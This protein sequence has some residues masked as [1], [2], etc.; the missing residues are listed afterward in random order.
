MARLG[1]DAD[2]L[3]TLARNCRATVD[4]LDGARLSLD[5]TVRA[6]FWL[7]VE[8]DGFRTT[9]TGS[10]ARQ[11]DHIARALAGVADDLHRQAADQR[12]TSAGGGAVAVTGG[13]CD[14]GGATAPT[15]RPTVGPPPI[16]TPAEVAEWWAQLSPAQR[17][18][19]LAQHPHALGNRQGLPASGRDQ[20]NRTAMAQDLVRLE[21]AERNGSLSD[22][23][24]REL[25]NIRH[26]QEYL[27]QTHPGDYPL[28]TGQRVPV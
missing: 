1:A 6:L 9:W 27:G 5:T 11:L 14:P 12:A 25:V 19:Y 8:A 10:Q 3:D 24:R 28:G 22:L 21:A 7:G 16:G 15:V 23:D 17:A 20:A 2:Q 18:A 13:R 4:R 26:V